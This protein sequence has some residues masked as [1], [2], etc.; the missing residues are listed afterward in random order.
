LGLSGRVPSRVDTATKAGLLA[1]LDQ[2]V[3]AGWTLRAACAVLDLGEMRAW[4]W[5]DRR[6]TDRLDDLPPGGN[7]AHGLLDEEA[8][9]ILWLF[10]HWGETDRSHRKLAHRGSYL[11]RVWVSP[12][13][14][15]RV[16]A[17][18][19]LRLR[20]LPRPVRSVRQPFPDWVEYRP[21]MLWIFDTTH[22]TRAGVAV[23]AIEDLVSRKW[24]AEI[25]S[26]EET[27][28]QVQAAFCEA[29]EAEGLMD[30][31]A[32]RLDGAVDL[33]R[34]DPARPIL[35][36]M[37]DNGPQMTS[38]STREFMALCAIH[39]H[40]GRPGTPTDQAWIESLFGHVKAEYP[41][42]HAIRDPA[43]LR[44]ELA[45][46][47][48]HYNGVRLHAGIGYVTPNDEH[49][50]RGKAIRKAREAGLEQ[51][52]LRRIAYHR[53]NR[54]PDPTVHPEHDLSE[55]PGDVG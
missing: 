7:P 45:Q 39:Q 54:T 8:V 5:L 41:Q 35:L 46:V 28:T 10:H 9:E 40:F 14:V 42:L 50:G 30:Q 29:L 27:S 34:D 4:R 55:E 15:R 26:V 44:A 3:E 2:A 17:A 13:S 1:L 33:A 43:T 6:A 47:R 53:A 21:G 36:A 37:S 32:A 19:G 38:G 12:S 24:L 20:P 18:E 22:F 48:E 23:T 51:A 49:E 31:I 25:V 11:G 52:R 16:L